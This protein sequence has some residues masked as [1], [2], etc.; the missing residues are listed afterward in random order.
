MVHDIDRCGLAQFR[1]EQG[2][3]ASC[4]KFVLAAATASE[5]EAV[6]ALHLAD[7][8]IVPA[9]LALVLAFRIHTGSSEEVGSVHEGLLREI[10]EDNGALHT[11]R[12]L[13]STQLRLSQDTTFYSDPFF[14][15][16]SQGQ[17]I[18]SIRSRAHRLD[19]EG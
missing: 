12:H 17:S 13:L 7:D 9:R 4:G 10:I 1:V 11:I 8:K 5:A 6:T 16:K 19:P 15:Q 18:F 14:P 2:G 3:A